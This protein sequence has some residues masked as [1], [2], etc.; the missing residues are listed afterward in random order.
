MASSTTNYPGNLNEVTKITVVGPGSLTAIF[1]NFK[2]IHGPLQWERYFIVDKEDIYYDDKLIT[3]LE[4]TDRWGVTGF[5]A[6]Q[7][8]SIKENQSKT[9]FLK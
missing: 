8:V 1:V 6:Q 9:L 7:V 5:T 4:P 2:E 3:H